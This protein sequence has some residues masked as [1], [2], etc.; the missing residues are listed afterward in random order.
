MKKTKGK[1]AQPGRDLLGL[2]NAVAGPV[3]P[4]L[5]SVTAGVNEIIRIARATKDVLPDARDLEG[6]C[7]KFL[8]VLRK[9]ISEGDGEEGGSS[10]GQHDKDKLYL[11]LE[12]FGVVVGD[13]QEEMLAIEQQSWWLRYIQR[14]RHASK[15]REYRRS[16]CKAFGDIILAFNFQFEKNLKILE[17]LCYTELEKLVLL[18]QKI[19][20]M[21]STLK[22]TQERQTR[23]LEAI[24]EKL[25]IPVD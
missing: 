16:L 14:E 11:A 4:P 24:A 12:N 20:S 19:E 15:I 10:R 17:H 22:E 6:L 9:H 13:I 18:N 5:A 21:F 2:T 1:T 8:D 25:D 3:F 23:L 7:E